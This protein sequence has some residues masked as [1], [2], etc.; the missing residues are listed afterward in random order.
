[1]SRNVS[2]SK[3]TEIADLQF[4]ENSYKNLFCTVEDQFHFNTATRKSIELF[5]DQLTGL[6]YTEKEVLLK[7]YINGFIRA[8]SRTVPYMHFGAHDR[9]LIKHIYLLLLYDIAN[10]IPLEK[11]EKRHY[12]RV[13]WL[14]KKTNPSVYQQNL[15]ANIL[16][17]QFVYAEYSSAFQLDLLNIDRQ[18]LLE[19]ILDIGCGEHGY[20]VEYF[21]S[22]H[23][24]AYGIDNFKGS[25]DHFY[26]CNWLEF[27]YGHE[28]WGTIISHLSFSS[29]FL[30]HILQNDGLDILYAQ[31]CMKI[32]ESI[33]PGGKWIYTPAVAFFEDLL[34]PEEYS[35][36]RTPVGADFHKTVITKL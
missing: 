28:K 19:P 21:R 9:L 17:E 10:K 22:Q 18:L 16:V 12:E 8:F 2:L 23:L 5:D 29:H 13:R 25:S 27:S 4:Q 7:N 1:M 15:N 36:R 26:S 20:L 34:S 14:I 24:D 32:L 30:H 11:I 35:V 6:S 3:L 31:T 33:V